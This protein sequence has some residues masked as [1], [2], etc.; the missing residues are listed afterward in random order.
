MGWFG[1]MEKRDGER[2]TARV[3]VSEVEAEQGRGRQKMRMDG[4]KSI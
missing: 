1:H 3:Y 4:V 2:L